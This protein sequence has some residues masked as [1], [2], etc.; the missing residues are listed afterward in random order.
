VFIMECDF[1]NEDMERAACIE[2]RHVSDVRT[3][4]SMKLCLNR[5]GS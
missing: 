2:W 3:H 4:R 1:D 5:G